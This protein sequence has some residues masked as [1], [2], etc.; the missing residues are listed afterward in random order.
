MAGTNLDTDSYKMADSSSVA[1][2]NKAMMEWF[3]QNLT[4]S[5]ADMQD[6]RLDLVGK[7]DLKDLSPATVITAQVDPLHDEGVAFA[8]K[9]KA[10]GVKVDAVNYDGVTHEF[11]GMGK[12]VGKAKQ[13][14]DLAVKNLNL[15]SPAT[16]TCYLP[17]IKRH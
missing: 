17:F 10:A 16:S 1:P 13:A 5:P 9:L 6:P 12:V 14:E 4:K 2:L 8:N 3:L 7:A 15:H 11:F